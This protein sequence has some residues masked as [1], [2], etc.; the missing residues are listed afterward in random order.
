MENNLFYYYT[1]H[2]TNKTFCPRTGVE[3]Q[4]LDDKNRGRIAIRG[5]QIVD[6]KNKRRCADTETILQ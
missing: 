3:S 6:L 2:L 5:R 1:G 4:I